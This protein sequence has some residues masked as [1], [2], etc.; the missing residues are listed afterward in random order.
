MRTFWQGPD[1]E[2]TW[3]AS[4]MALSLADTSGRGGVLAAG[5]VLRNYPGRANG[6]AGVPGV[7]ASAAGADSDVKRRTR[8]EDGFQ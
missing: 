7:A 6:M 3:P 8:R 4:F 1:S 5:M 2:R